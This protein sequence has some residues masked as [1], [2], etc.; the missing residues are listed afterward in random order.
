MPVLLWVGERSFATSESEFRQGEKPL[1]SEREERKEIRG[2]Q[3]EGEDPCCGAGDSQV[4]FQGTDQ[5]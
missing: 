1:Y 4:E 5:F 3:R 2:S